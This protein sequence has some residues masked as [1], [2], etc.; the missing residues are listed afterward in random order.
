MLAILG[1]RKNICA[2]QKCKVPSSAKLWHE[3]CAEIRSA[4]PCPLYSAVS[5]FKQLLVLLQLHR[6]YRS[7]PDLFLYRNSVFK[8]SLSASVM[9]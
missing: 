6:T 7:T 5:V 3:G 4:P 1:G 8:C 9:Y 2:F